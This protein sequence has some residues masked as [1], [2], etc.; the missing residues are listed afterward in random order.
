MTIC[1]GWGDPPA[2]GL[3]A[4]QDCLFLVLVEEACPRGR[5]QF[6][7]PVN[8]DIAC[9]T[10]PDFDNRI[11][12]LATTKISIKIRTYPVFVFTEEAIS[13]VI[14]PWPKGSRLLDGG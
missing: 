4:Y 2:R 7:V 5:I 13:M 8:P 1:I 9:P 11:S 6:I 12:Y 14:F 3:A 10:F